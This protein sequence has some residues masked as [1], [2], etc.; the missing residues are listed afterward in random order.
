[1]ILRI[2]AG[3]AI[4]GILF[5]VMWATIRAG[6]NI[7]HKVRDDAATTSAFHVSL[8]PAHPVPASRLQADAA[9]VQRRARALGYVAYASASHG[10]I[11]VGTSK[12]MKP[13][14]ALILIAEGAQQSGELNDVLVVSG[15]G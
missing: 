14:D 3:L 15:S 12:K 4:L 13:G 5:L 2:L 7:N 1:M 11:T 9:I 10:V 6:H 8:K